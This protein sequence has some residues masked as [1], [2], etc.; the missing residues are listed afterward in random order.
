MLDIV[1]NMKNSEIGKV[2]KTQKYMEKVGKC[3][4]NLE[5]VG[6]RQKKLEGLEND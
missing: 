5:N 2:G 1:R 4:E 6:K 3:L